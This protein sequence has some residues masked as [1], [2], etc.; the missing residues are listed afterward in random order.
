MCV[1]VY[2]LKFYFFFNLQSK[3]NV[4]SVWIVDFVCVNRE[5]FRF[6]NATI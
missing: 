2:N 6:V 3:E 1:A 4:G 5:H